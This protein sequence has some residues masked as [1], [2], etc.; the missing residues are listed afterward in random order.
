MTKSFFLIFGLLLLLVFRIQAQSNFMCDA[1]GNTYDVQPDHVFK[2]S[3]NF[4]L[5]YRLSTLQ[6]GTSAQ[7]DLTN[8][9]V[10]F[11][12]FQDQGSLVFFDNMLN[13]LEDPVFLNERFQGQITC[14]A[15]SKG[16][17]LWLY[18]VNSSTLIR[19]DRQFGLLSKSANLSYLLKEELQPI[20]II[21][22]GQRVYVIDPFKGIF[23][24]S[25]F[26]TL[27]SKST[28]LTQ[29]FVYHWNDCIYFRTENTLNAWKNT[30]AMPVVLATIEPSEIN[31]KNSWTLCNGLPFY[32]QR[33][34]GEKR[35]IPLL[36]N[37]GK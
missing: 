7:L 14:V 2:Y 13:V 32:I 35:E 37:L 19:T 29:E 11:L 28:Y 15:G 24:F 8:P 9:L 3:S 34:T 36:E 23:I 17:A 16:D 12:F 25:L 18:D 26:G 20:Q 1:L 6:Y 10:P 5:E 4:D 27:E 33:E 30:D 22:S 31:K 21:E